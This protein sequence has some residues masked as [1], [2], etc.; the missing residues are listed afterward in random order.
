MSDDMNL[1]GMSG[2][3]MFG[4]GEIRNRA[5]VVR[6]RPTPKEQ[7]LRNQLGQTTLGHQRLLAERKQMHADLVHQR[8]DMKAALDLLE[9]GSVRDAMQVLKAA[10][11]YR[12]R[13]REKRKGKSGD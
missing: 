7:H 8:N 1:T 13:T 12:E 11:A 3:Q 6:D 4:E 10:L 5:R 9:M 2:G